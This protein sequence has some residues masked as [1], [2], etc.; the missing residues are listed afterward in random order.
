MRQDD[1]YAQSRINTA[2]TNINYAMFV[3][4]VTL[5]I[6][7]LIVQLTIPPIC[8]VCYWYNVSIFRAAW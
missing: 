3:I 7:I 5:Q 6:Y 1:N 8:C 2:L 4:Q